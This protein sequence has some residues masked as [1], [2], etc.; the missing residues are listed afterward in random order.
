MVLDYALDV[1]GVWSNGA[2]SRTISGAIAGSGL[3]V[4]TVPAWMELWTQRKRHPKS[5]HRE[6]TA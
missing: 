3:A 2:M 4:F 5:D 1:L 6:V